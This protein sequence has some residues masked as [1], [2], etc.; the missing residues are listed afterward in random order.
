MSPGKSLVTCDHGTIQRWAEAR[1]AK[2]ARVAGT[3]DGDAGLLRLDF[4]G[5]SGGGRLEDISWDEFFEKFERE[6]LCLVYQETTAEGEKSNF[7][8]IISRESAEAKS[9]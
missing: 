7:N 8:K 5:Y 6:K 2:P 9:A 3:G 1:G 4:P